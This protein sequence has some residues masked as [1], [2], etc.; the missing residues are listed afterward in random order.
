MLP[1]YTTIKPINSNSTISEYEPDNAYDSYSDSEPEH[2]VEPEHED[3]TDSD[4]EPEIKYE[5]E[6]ELQ[7][8]DFEL[9][10]TEPELDSEPELDMD[11]EYNELDSDNKQQPVSNINKTEYLDIDPVVIEE[12]KQPQQQLYYK[13]EPKNLNGP[14]GS[15]GSTGCI[16]SIV[17][18]T[19]GGNSFNYYVD[20]GSTGFGPKYNP[21]G[22]TG[23]ICTIYYPTGMSGSNRAT[24]FSSENTDEDFIKYYYPTGN[25]A[26]NQP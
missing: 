23:A 17:S 1:K 11:L 2:D 13:S 4:V 21:T 6:P 26:S 20:T 9:E 12:Y 3:G 8:S 15:H 10:G 14:T 7:E 19:T 5:N 24:Y 25:T 18:G 16:Y 22:T